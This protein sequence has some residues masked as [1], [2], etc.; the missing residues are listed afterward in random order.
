MTKKKEATFE[1]NLDT[2]QAIVEEME[3]G[4]INL[5]ELIEKY[6]QGIELSK[7]CMKALKMAGDT[8][9]LLV[10]DDGEVEEFKIEGE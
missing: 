7:K 10:K 3:K 1:E 9:D 4:D 2:L 8:M 5:T 6:S